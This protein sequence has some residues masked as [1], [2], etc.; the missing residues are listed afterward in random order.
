MALPAPA[1]AQTANG[2]LAAVLRRPDRGA[3]TL[4][5]PA[6]ARC[7]RRPAVT[8]SP[9]RPGRRTATSSRSPT[10]GKINVLDL[11][12]RTVDVVARRRV[13]APATS[14]QHGRGRRQIG[15]R[16]VRTPTSALVSDADGRQ[17]AGASARELDLA[18]SAFALASNIDEYAYT[19]GTLLSGPASRLRARRSARPD[20]PGLVADGTA[21]AYVDSR[22][23]LRPRALRHHGSSAARPRTRASPPLPGELAALGAG[24]QR[25]RVPPR[26]HGPGRCR[27]SRAPRPCRCPASTGATAVDWQ[28]C[29]AAR[30]S[31]LPVRARA[32]VQR[33]DRAGDDA[34]RP[35]RR[36]ARSAVHRS[37]RAAA[38]TRA[39]LRAA[40][41]A[42]VSGSVYT[43]RPGFVGQD[44]VTYRVSNGGARLGPR[45]RHGLRRPAA[46]RGR[47]G[48]APEPPVGPGRGAVPERAGQADAGPQAH[49]A[50]PAG[51]RS[52]VLVHRAPRRH[53]AGQEEEALQG[54]GAQARAGRRAA[55]SRCGSSSRPSRRA[56]LKTV[57][58]TGTVARG[59]RRHPARQ[60][61]GR[62]PPLILRS[63]RGCI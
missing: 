40:I 57:F 19:V 47:S 10:S 13:R 42:R 55:C 56:R 5:A 30:R 21:L 6:C 17:R 49:D 58:I 35:A 24:R 28:P 25:A 51:V 29:T 53:A 43:P 60:A 20:T 61:R 38:A 22:P 48:A 16:R 34:D 54:H 41:T 36:A 52:G 14:T 59:D 15:F 1:L 50:R 11:A 31:R 7:R 39:R 9:G 62:R 44:S 27:R 8:R 37:R 3:S 4:T 32:D 12:T 45:A 18:T 63:G 2:Q 46:G 33:D 23:R 26:R